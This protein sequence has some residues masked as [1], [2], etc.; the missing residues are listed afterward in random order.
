MW[1]SRVQ[2]IYTWSNIENLQTLSNDM[3]HLDEVS[4]FFFLSKKKKEK[5]VVL[6]LELSFVVS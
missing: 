4:I 5:N 2:D 6:G 3:V 1:C